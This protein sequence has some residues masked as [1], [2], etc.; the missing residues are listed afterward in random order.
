MLDRQFGNIIVE[1]DSCPEV[2]LTHV[3]E[4][5]DARKVMQRNNWKVRRIGK[6]WIHGC[7]KCG[8]PSS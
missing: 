4:F 3:P 7:P 6:D 5:E 8:V 1:C 2:L